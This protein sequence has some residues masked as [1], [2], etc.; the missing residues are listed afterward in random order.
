MVR[1]GYCRKE[2]TNTDVIIELGAHLV[3][4]ACV[5]PSMVRSM[6]IAKS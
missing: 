3:F 1:F 4:T 2:Y 6:D 5:T